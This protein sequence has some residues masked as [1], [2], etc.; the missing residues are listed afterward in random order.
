MNNHGIIQMK[1][2]SIKIFDELR[3]AQVSRFS[4]DKHCKWQ[5]VKAFN[6]DKLAPFSMLI[7]RAP[8]RNPIQKKAIISIGSK[9]IKSEHYRQF[10]I[11]LFTPIITSNTKKLI[12]IDLRCSRSVRTIFHHLLC[13]SRNG[14]INCSAFDPRVG[15]NKSIDC[16]DDSE[17]TS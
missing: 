9:L 10:S 4:R 14:L 13:T 1:Q 8:F 6:I 15:G 12:H 7:S 2:F 3:D 5:A 11:T 16:W 17:K